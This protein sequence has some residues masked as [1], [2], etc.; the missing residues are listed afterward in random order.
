M[1]GSAPLR[2][3]TTPPA[4]VSMRARSCRGGGL[5]GSALPR[6]SW[7][8]TAKQLGNLDRVRRGAFA[9]VVPHHPEVQY[10]LKI[11][12]HAQMPD[13]HDVPPGVLQ[14]EG[15]APVVDDFDAL[16]S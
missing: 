1:R 3:T 9:Q 4:L 16:H 2:S 6:W 13:P 15:I 11:A 14:G 7:S 12:I 5:F 10:P 8:G